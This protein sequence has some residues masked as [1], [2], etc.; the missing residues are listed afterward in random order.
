PNLPGHK[1][2][3]AT[4]TC[5]SKPCTTACSTSDPE[6]NYLDKKQNRPASFL[7]KK[8]PGGSGKKIGWRRPTLP[9]R[10]RCSTIGAGG[11][12]FRVRDGIGWTPSA[13][14]TN[15][16]VCRLLFYLCDNV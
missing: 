8:I 13:V 7:F 12:N 10:L 2:S 9:Q 3:T 1:A 11:L 14:A 16:T 6:K 5:K 15:Q 4:A